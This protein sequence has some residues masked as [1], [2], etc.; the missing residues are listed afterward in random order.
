[1]RPVAKELDEMTPEE[2]IAPGSPFW[3]FMKKAYELK[4]HTILL[5]DTY[6][7][8]GATTLQQSII[9]ERL[10]GEV[11]ALP[12]SWELH[13]STRLRQLL[14]IR[15]EVMLW[16]MGIDRIP[17]VNCENACAGASTALYLGYT[18]IKAGMFDV[19]LALGSE[20]ITHE[21]AALVSGRTP[22]AWT[23]RIS[24]RTS[25]CSKS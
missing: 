9:I 20:K 13:L 16:D 24:R 3:D 21:S 1:M 12:F 8:L 10:A 6:G 22:P 19:V 14:S 23:W 4:Y 17:I 2:V 7:G 25:K 5:P 18:A 15:G 11:V